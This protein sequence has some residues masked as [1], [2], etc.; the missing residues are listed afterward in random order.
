MEEA[1]KKNPKNPTKSRF[2]RS[3]FDE[4]MLWCW[5]C[6]RVREVRTAD[7]PDFSNILSTACRQLS[8]L[9]IS[10][11]TTRNRDTYRGQ[12]P[13]HCVELSSS[14]G[15]PFSWFHIQVLAVRGK[16]QFPSGLSSSTTA[17]TWWKAAEMTHTANH[18]APSDAIWCCIQIMHEKRR[19]AESVYGC[20]CVA[21][22]RNL[23]K[24]L[25]SKATGNW[26]LIYVLAFNI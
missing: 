5:G 20:R 10:I 12:K 22:T 25:Q 19:L 24:S 3:I 15:I 9:S 11:A 2:N 6:R 16:P 23:F 7:V 14:K 26:C 4:T 21:E 13:K 1:K 8:M 17:E 18:N